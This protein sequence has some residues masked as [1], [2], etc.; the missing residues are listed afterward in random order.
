M[1]R[2]LLL[3]ACCLTATTAAELPAWKQA[4]QP[5]DD[6]WRQTEQHF[7]FN[8][9]AEPQTLDPQIMTG[10]PEGNLAEALFEGLTALHPETLAPKPGI[11]HSWTISP[12]GL[13]YTFN[14]RDGLTWSDGTPLRAQDVIASW[15]HALT[16]ATGC[17]YAN[18][19]YPIA[20]ARAFHRDPAAGEEAWARVGLTAPDPLTLE[21]RLETPC[22][23][24]LSLT[25]FHTLFPVPLHVIREHGDRWTRPEHIVCNGPFQLQEW[26]PRQHIVL[27]ANPR[28]WDADFVKLDRVT[29]F[30]YDELD[31]AYKLFK[32]GEIDWM[33]AVPLD[34]LDALKRDPDY[35][36]APYLGIYY[37]RVNVTEPPLDDIRVRRALA[38]S[39]NRQVV[40]KDILRAGEIPLAWFCPR[41][42]AGYR[43]ALQMP[44]DR[45]AARAQLAEAGFAGGADFPRL[46]VLYN[47]SERHQAIMENLAQQWERALG[48]TVSPTNTEWKV[49]LD[50]LSSLDYQLA[51]S[52]WIGDFV[53][54]DTFF[55]IW[56]T[57]DGNN[58]TGWGDPTY[59][60]LVRRAA[61]ERDP[62]QRL[63]LF[64]QMDR[65]LIEQ[66]PG[67][68]IYSYVNQGM[69]SERVF[70]FFHNL[71]D[72]HPLQYVY[73]ED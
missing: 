38:W 68:P 43:P 55:N 7:R 72:L 13:R 4:L 54:P 35:Y 20:G 73:L 29:V 64:Q 19:L 30:P 53:D 69:L 46:E 23:Y 50:R 26:K 8:N 32:Q 48:I 25:A 57:G 61:A 47:K 49:Y 33:N 1:L 16:P 6:R 24:F 39:V 71:R 27:Q 51:R 34:R 36:V 60:A 22:A 67:I 56:R 31:T 63:E 52:G 12:D 66:V 40:T 9:S 70:G 62:A 58:R 21:V 14:L 10:V 41:D 18:L 5:P 37:I 3:F 59:D 15:R 65:M 17:K 42:T 45:D 28:Y 44:Y 11:A 2:F